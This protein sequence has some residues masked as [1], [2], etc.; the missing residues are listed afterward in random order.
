M[1]EAGERVP[2]P[3]GREEGWERPGKWS[4]N[5]GPGGRVGEAGEGVPGP[6]GREEGLGRDGKEPW[7]QGPGRKGGRG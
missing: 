6:W 5:R 1:G 7:D 3:G 2:G 4:R